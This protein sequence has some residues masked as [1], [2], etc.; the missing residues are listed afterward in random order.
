M[1]EPTAPFR[2]SI[3]LH[4]LRL[5]SLLQDFVNSVRAYRFMVMNTDRQ[6]KGNLRLRAL[7]VGWLDQH[8]QTKAHDCNDDLHVDRQRIVLAP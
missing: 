3:T 5:R 4:L 2:L 6:S 7:R 8:Q 1:K